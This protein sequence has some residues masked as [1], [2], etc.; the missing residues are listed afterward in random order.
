MLHKAEK[1]AR[2]L[3]AAAVCFAFMAHCGNVSISKKI[4]ARDIPGVGYETNLG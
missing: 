3:F 4:A 1:I 2:W